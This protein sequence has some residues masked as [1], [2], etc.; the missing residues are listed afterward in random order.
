MAKGLQ[1]LVTTNLPLDG[2]CSSQA[3]KDKKV[4]KYVQY[5]MRIL[6]ARIQSATAESAQSGTSQ[7]HVAQMLFKKIQSINEKAKSGKAQ[8]GEQLER[9]QNL[10]AKF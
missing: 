4:Q 1:E 9:F 5:F 8:T 3:D 7:D 10:N 2:S 6:S